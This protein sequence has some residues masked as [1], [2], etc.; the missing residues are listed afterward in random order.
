MRQALGR[1]VRQHAA[2]PLQFYA[3]PRR[4]HGRIQAI[5]RLGRGNDHEGAVR[6]IPRPPGVVEC[7]FFESCGAGSASGPQ[8]AGRRNVEQATGRTTCCLTEN[9]RPPSANRWQPSVTLGKRTLCK[10]GGGL[11]CVADAAQRRLLA[12]RK[13]EPR[14]TVQTYVGSRVLSWCCGARAT[15]SGTHGGGLE[16]CEHASRTR[17]GVWQDKL[18]VQDSSF[19]EE[20]PGL[21]KNTPAQRAGVCQS[22]PPWLRREGEALCPSAAALRRRCDWVGLRTGT[23]QGCFKAFQGFAPAHGSAYRAP[24]AAG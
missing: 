17:G 2:L 23:R 16:D 21:S 22:V 15:S 18:S 10:S 20:S 5:V 13:G 24:Q 4:G 11:F 8:G 14:R 7:H 19:E 12:P 6:A 1:R 3:P 9:R